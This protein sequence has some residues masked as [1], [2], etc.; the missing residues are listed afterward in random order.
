MLELFISE[1]AIALYEILVILLLLFIRIRQFRRKREIEERSQISNRK[2]R[3]VQLD[4][5]LKNPDAQVEWS[6]RSSPYE[7]EYVHANKA[8]SSVLPKFQIEIEVHAET[9]VQRY[10]FDLNQEVTIGRDEKNVLPINEKQM[11][12]QCCTVYVKDQAVYI[13][14]DNAA[15]PVSIRRGKK[16]HLLQNSPVKLQSKDVLSIGTT[17]LNIMLYEN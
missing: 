8:K 1:K 5:M 14:K 2:R 4:E 6:G 10:L 17:D 11:A 16:K 7:V 15:T 13:K 9:S 3:N 12:K